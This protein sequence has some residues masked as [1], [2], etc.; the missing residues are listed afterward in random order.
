LEGPC[1]EWD[2]CRKVDVN[3][4]IVLEIVNTLR[5]RGGVR[6]V[7]AGLTRTLVGFWRPVAEDGGEYGA[8]SMGICIS[9][10]AVEEYLMELDA[11]ERD[12]H[13]GDLAA[14]SRQPMIP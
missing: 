1:R 5:G 10:E 13:R 2:V 7:Y 9:E 14:P 12:R 3:D 6:I 4:V 11:E 8:S